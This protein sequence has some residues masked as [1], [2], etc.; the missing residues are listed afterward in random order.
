MEVLAILTCANPPSKHIALARVATLFALLTTVGWTIAGCG[1]GDDGK[2]VAAEVASDWVESNS[3]L[4]S[5]AFLD[6]V[7][8][9]ESA[10]AGPSA[11]AHSRGIFWEG[12]SWTYSE[13]VRLREGRYQVTATAVADVTVIPTLLDDRRYVATV[14]FNLEVDTNDKVVASWFPDLGSATAEGK[15]RS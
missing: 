4:V 10:T 5:G 11:G 6:L 14:P 15:G 2:A 12:L 13:P 3:E 8:R 7:I 1:S 9:E